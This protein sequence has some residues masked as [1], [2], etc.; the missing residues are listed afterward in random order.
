[1]GAA[2]SVIV[3]SRA[4]EHVAQYGWRGGDVRFLLGASGGPKWLILGHLDRFLSSQFLFEG[5][6][7]PLLAIGS[8]VGT[9]RHAC[10]AMAD[11]ASAFD[12]FEDIYLRYEYSPRPSA[13]EVSDSSFAMLEHVLGPGGAREVLANPQLHSYIVT[14]RGIGFSGSEG[15]PSLVLGM[16]MSAIGNML[17]RRLLSRHFQRVIFTSEHAPPLIPA[18]FASQ[19]VVTEPHEL[20]R[21]LH[22]SGSIPF[23]FTGERDLGGAPEGHYWDGG[24][25]DYHFCLDE[26][27][28]FVDQPIV[29]YPHFRSKLTSGWF[30]KFLPWRRNSAAFCSS[31]VLVSPSDEFIA[32]LPFKKI[33]DRNDFVRLTPEDRRAYWSECVERS[34]EL[35]AEFEALVAGPDPLAGVEVQR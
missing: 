16:A 35:R 15:G 1:M 34:Q 8:S 30:D 26:L 17:D 7:K 23:V 33:P 13:Q 11:P 25:I 6:H 31:L 21:V 27:Q 32:S 28:G 24:I 10:M 20:A 22:A 2:L 14:A 5:R 3:G 18:G 9:W 29:L 12:R 4:A 19:Q